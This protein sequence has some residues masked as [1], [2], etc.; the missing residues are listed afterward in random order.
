MPRYQQA[1]GIIISKQ[2]LVLEAASIYCVYF[3]GKL[4]DKLKLLP[5]LHLGIMHSYST[6]IHY[7]KDYQAI[8]YF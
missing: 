6:P 4:L 5:F 7:F 2:L 8:I 3:Q 1:L